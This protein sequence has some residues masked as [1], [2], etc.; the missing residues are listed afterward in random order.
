MAVKLAWQCGVILFNWPRLM[1]KFPAILALVLSAALLS[2][3]AMAQ[4]ESQIMVQSL[5]PS[6]QL[7]Y[8]PAT[9]QWAGTNGVCAYYSNAVLTADSASGNS[10]AGNVAADGH[11][12]IESDDQVWAGEHMDYNF[13]THQMRAEEFRTG[14][15]PMFAGGTGLEGNMSNRVYTAQNGY[16]TTDDISDPAY[17]IKAS[18]IRL[19]PGKSVE[20]WNAVL[21][22][23]KVPVFYFPYY[24][25][26]L[27]QRANNFTFTPGFRSAY[28]AFLLTTY[29]WF[30]NS[31]VDGSFHADY[32]TRRG[33]GVGPD[34]KLH[35]GAWGEAD[36][37]YYYT[38]DINP[39]T[40]TNGFP[41]YANVPE[42]RQ[43]FY[44]GW[45]AT[46]ATNLN[47]KALVNYQSDPLVLRDFFTGDYAA[48]PQPNTFIEGQKYSDNW[49]LDALATPR[50]NSFFN[51]VERLPDVKLTGY[52][53]QVLGTPIYYDSESSIGWYQ[54]FVSNN[55]TN[56]A[57][58]YSMDGTNI[59]SA[60][61][62]D[63]YHQLT[64]PWTFFHWLNVTP[65]VGGRFTYY[66][67]GNPTNHPGDI[68]RGVFNT[69]M[70]VSFKAS[71]LWPDAKSSLLDVDGLRHIIEPSANYVFVP[72]PS[73][74]P[75][76]LPQ[77][78]SE[79]PALLIAP[80][81]F[82]DYDNIDSIDSM[83]VIRFGLRNVLQTKRDGQIDDLVNWNLML[84]W[85]LD[86]HNVTVAGVTSEQS[87]L[88]DLYSEFS[89]RP[90]TWLTL[91]E[92]LRYDTEGDHLNLSFHQITFAPN[93][94]WSWGLGHLYLRG[95]IWGGGE[96]SQNDFVISTA[97]LRLTDNWGLRAQHDFNITTGRLQQQF[98]SVYRDM[99]SWT[100]A[101]TFRVEDDI[102]SNPDYTVALQ[103]SLKAMPSQH[104]GEDVVNPYRLVGE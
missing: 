90:R 42:D 94:R 34:V 83:N 86:P 13:M 58:F 20:M 25:R 104:V 91:E 11:V 45:Q 98:Y 75:S 57:G 21:W 100:C 46:P 49:S 10:K 36:I 71:S 64:L 92:M 27:D 99:R 76:Q 95:G 7:D 72:N 67:E 16:V 60:M 6:G 32:R 55:Q 73:V 31:A 12:R 41:Q 24:V 14:K 18:R 30:L 82:P 63:T 23:G 4:E 8:N 102:N 50:V 9:G 88:D 85:R 33:P 15:A 74:S 17:R 35:L 65:R 5:T 84:D 37:R 2:P 54:Q 47:L 78:D 69:G 53:Q 96:W 44:L 1:T 38:H 87:H 66:S 48:N 81:T 101:L 39:N 61:R 77:F 79:L 103:V 19:I 52:R 26:S 51:Q 43:R 56:A 97:F 29:N 22:A 89:I 3:R 59:A 40:S 68:S 62:A 70:E 93:D 28:G 80:V